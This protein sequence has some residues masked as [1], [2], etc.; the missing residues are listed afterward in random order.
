VQALSKGT[1]LLDQV[2]EL[3][4]TSLNKIRD[5]SNQKKV[6]KRESFEIESKPVEW[7]EEKPTKFIKKF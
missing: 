4:E 6:S 5:L 7:Q 3:N 2:F 1:V